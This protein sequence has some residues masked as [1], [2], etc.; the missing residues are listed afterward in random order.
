MLAAERVLG[1]RVSGMFYWGFK[2]AIQR[3]GWS[4]PFPPGWREQAIET[5]MRIAG[6]IRAG[7]I[8]PRPTDPDKCRYCDLR[9]V[10]R[11]ETAAILAEEAPAWD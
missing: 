2:G 3:R 9:D 4:D 5:I 7:R 11:F 1:L 6:E 8:E 10:C